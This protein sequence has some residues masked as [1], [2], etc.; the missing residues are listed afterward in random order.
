MP[1]ARPR[2]VLAAEVVVDPV[3]P[4]ATARVP[5]NVMVP[6]VVIGLPETVRPVV[7]PDRATDVTVPE[8]PVEA[9]VI[10]PAPLVMEI[11]EPAV[12]VDF[13]SVLPVVLPISSWP[14]V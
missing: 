1:M 9:M 6:D 13:V 12:R 11:P 10:E 8:P 2:A 7:P 4:L 3:P 14:F 5:A